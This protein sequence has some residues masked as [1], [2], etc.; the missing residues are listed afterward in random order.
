MKGLIY[1]EKMIKYKKL[2]NACEDLLLIM[3]G[4]SFVTE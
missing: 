2:Q 1:S 4:E 3:E